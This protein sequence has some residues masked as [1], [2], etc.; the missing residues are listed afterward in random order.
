MGRSGYNKDCDCDN[1]RLIMWRGAVASAFRGKR[2]QAFLKE[3]LSAL[4]GLPEKKL[5]ADDLERD[6]GVC[7]I[8]AVGRARGIDMSSVHEY[9]YAAPCVAE[10]FG[11]PKA[12]AA[13]I[14]WMNDEAVYWSE[15]E[16]QRYTRVRDWLKQVIVTE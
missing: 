12:L 3:M 4:D 7:A 13:E 14:M 11:I 10:I 8:G 5:I 6:G 1:W 16:E 9:D 2:G 15:T